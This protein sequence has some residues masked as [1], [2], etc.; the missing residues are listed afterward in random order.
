MSKLAK[1]CRKY[2]EVTGIME[3]I[4]DYE[5]YLGRGYKVRCRFY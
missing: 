4:T 2:G 5:M 3:S 1:F